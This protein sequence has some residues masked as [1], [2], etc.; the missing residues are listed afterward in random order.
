MSQLLEDVIA[1][2]GLSGIT[3]RGLFRRV[4]EN[5]GITVDSATPQDYRA[6]LPTIGQRLAIYVDPRD[7]NRRLLAI[8]RAIDAYDEAN[9]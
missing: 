9:P 8:E 5:M 2:S 4:L 6:A 1:A 7:V 3:A